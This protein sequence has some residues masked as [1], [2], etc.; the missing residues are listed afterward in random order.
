MIHPYHFVAC[1][2]VGACIVSNNNKIVGIGYNGFPLRV[3]DD[4][5]DMTWGKGQPGE[6]VKTK[7]PYGEQNYE[8]FGYSS[9]MHGVYDSIVVHA[10]VNAIMH[11]TCIDLK[12]CTL[13]TT[14]FP[15]NECAKVI[16]QCGIERIFYLMDDHHDRVYMNASRQLLRR[17]RYDIIADFKVKTDTSA[18]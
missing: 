7:Y 5:K 8:Y 13:Y 1:I 14:L 18:K 3:S 17:A 12:G 15:C 11:K 9:F 2:Q 10:E 4:D 16:V 6:P